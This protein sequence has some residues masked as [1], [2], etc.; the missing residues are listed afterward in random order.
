[1]KEL[2]FPQGF[3]WGTSTAGHQI[4]GNN[5]HSDWW[6]FEEKGKIYDGTKS[7]KAVD[8]WNRFEEDHRLMKE[9]SYPAFRL[10]IEWAKLE[11]EKGRYDLSALNHYRKIFDSL[12]DKGIKICLTMYHWVLPLWVAKAG[13]W[14]N[15]E[16][17]N[18]W[19]NYCEKA[20]KEFAQYPDIWVTLNEPL[21]P[22][23][24]GYLGG[25]FPPEK[26]SFKSFIGVVAAL[27]RAHLNCYEVIHANTS[28]APDGTAV[29]AGVAQAYQWIEPWGSK[30]LKGLY[31]RFMT[32]L[33]RL[34]SFE[35]WDKAICSGRLKFPLRRSVEI[36]RLKGSY[37]YSGINYYFRFSLRFDAG[38]RGEGLIDR[39]SIPEGIEKTQMGWQ[40]YPKGFYL[41]IKDNWE[42][43]KK[44]IYILENGIADDKDLQRPK[45]LLEHL[46]QVH[47]AIKD[48]CDL[49]G[50]FQWA[51]TDNFEWR[52]GFAKKFGLIECDYK[53]P[54][55]TRKPRKSA[56]MYSEIIRENGITEEIVKKYSPEAEEGVFGESPALFQRL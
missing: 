3:I 54:N 12:R 11:P 31:E 50:Y 18:W 2:R 7:A 6:E 5:I 27:L 22:A 13:G 43:F 41:V 40:I 15:P 36:P 20:V 10:G 21:V 45:Y 33:F 52:E 19:T 49:R 51:F 28:S 32:N 48:G 14:E 53:D 23:A 8:Y 56:Y 16:A 42:R 39:D 46:A 26:K 37:D 55:L 1:M 17:V 34:G 44:P 25:E 24:A 9:L 38:K 29:K 30:G 4:E 47:R 35:A